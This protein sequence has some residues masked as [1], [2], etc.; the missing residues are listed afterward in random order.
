MSVSR[1][2]IMIIETSCQLSAHQKPPVW[3]C[4]NNA[5]TKNWWRDSSDLSI[6][7]HQHHVILPDK[8]HVT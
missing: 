5:H 6:G 2:Y 8:V 3:S 4:V 7:F 1:A